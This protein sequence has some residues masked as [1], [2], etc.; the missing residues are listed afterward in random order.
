MAVP[1]RTPARRQ[2]IQGVT[3]GVGFFGHPSPQRYPVGTYSVKGPASQRATGGYSVPRFHGSRLSGGALHRVCVAGHAGQSFRLP[4][5][6]P[7]PCW[8]QRLSL[9]RWVPMTMASHTFACAAPGRL[10]DGI[11]GLRLPGSAVYPRFRPLTT[12]RRPGG[13]A[14]TP[15]PGGRGLHP[16]GEQGDKTDVLRLAREQRLSVSQRI[17]R[18]VSAHWRSG[19]VSGTKSATCRHGPRPVSQC[20]R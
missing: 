6:Y 14:F 5:P 18:N 1:C 2:H 13:D 12:S 17:A 15:A 11:P 10:L 19:W 9:L 7:V 3:P 16:H 8:L 20:W 4:A